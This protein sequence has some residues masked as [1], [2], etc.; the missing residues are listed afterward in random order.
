[1]VF[2][3]DKFSVEAMK[4][5]K[6]RNFCAAVGSAHPAGRRANLT[7][8][9]LA[10]PAILRH[11]Q[12]P[13]FLRKSIG[14][15]KKQDVAFSVFFGQPV[16]VAEHHGL[17]EQVNRLVEDVTMINSI[18]PDI[19]WCDLET[20]VSTAALRRRTP[21]GV[22]HVR[23]YSRA[24]QIANDS[25][26]PKRFQ[27]EWSHSSECPPVEQVLQ[28]G[29]PIDSFAVDDSK[30]SLAVELAPYSR[31][32]LSVV[33]RNDYS[34]LE[35]LGFLWDAKAFIRRRLSEARDNHLSKNQFAMSVAQALKRRVF[36][37]VF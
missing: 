28:Y 14:H 10:Q 1:M 24:V 5:L 30:I 34:S 4:V 9:D 32:T 15:V 31:R 12:F 17:F 19:Q 27:V 35:G 33:Y 26:S 37:K 25:D 20:A 11:G 3:Q 7:F 13:L 21:D 6:S 2:P 22:C 18:E 23:A 36:S 16:L 29:A 8:G